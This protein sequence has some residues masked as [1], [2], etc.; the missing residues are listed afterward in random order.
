[1]LENL[2]LG[3]TLAEAAEKPVMETD[4]DADADTDG[5]EDADILER[6]SMADV[7]AACRASHCHD[8][9]SAL[10][11][12]YNTVIGERGGRLSGGQKQRL[13]IARALLRKPR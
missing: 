6:V 13:V 2:L 5:H 3:L 10:P 4:R 11:E 1:M 9:I 12:G 7:I 8:F